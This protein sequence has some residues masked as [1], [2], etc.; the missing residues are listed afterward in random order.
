[1]AL[2]DDIDID[3]HG[4]PE[5][6]DSKVDP[7]ALVQKNMEADRFSEWQDMLKEQRT[8][9]REIAE[10]KAAL[11]KRTEELREALLVTSPDSTYRGVQLLQPSS[12]TSP[13]QPKPRRNLV[14]LNKP[15]VF[16][17]SNF[18]TFITGLEN[19]MRFTEVDADSVK[20]AVLVS[21]LG[22][23]VAVYR[24]WQVQHPIGTYASLVDHL[25]CF[26]S[27][28][29]DSLAAKVQFRNRTRRSNES[30]AQFLMALQELALIAYSAEPA[31]IDLAVREQFLL[32]LNASKVQEHIMS[33]DHSSAVALLHRAQR[34]RDSLSILSASKQSNSTLVSTV[35]APVVEVPAPVPTPRARQRGTTPGPTVECFNC[36]QKG[37]VWRRCPRLLSAY[38]APENR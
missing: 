2:R 26:F 32:G 10:T 14:K 1:M 37:H 5:E 4:T 15:Q 18:E 9:R 34:L 20:V 6:V 23:A 30:F 8:L 19:Y 33:E 11:N 24:A 17:G 27:N 7:S 29:P 28:K 35:E 12:E 31:R 16:D 3:F 38:K 36:R 21:Y 13:P 22:P 25:R